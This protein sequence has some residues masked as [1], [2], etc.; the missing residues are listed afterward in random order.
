MPT[1]IPTTSQGTQT[2][3]A[4]KFYVKVIKVIFEVFELSPLLQSTIKFCHFSSHD[5]GPGLFSPGSDVTQCINPACLHILKSIIIFQNQLLSKVH[6]EVDN[7]QNSDKELIYEDEIPISGPSSSQLLEPE[8]GC[9][10]L[11][12]D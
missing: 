3:C 1:T 9:I 6:V 2:S 10:L 12:T 8:N 11:V 7:V 4:E 5:F